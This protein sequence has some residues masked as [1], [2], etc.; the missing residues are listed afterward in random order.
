V[1][2]EEREVEEAE[3]TEGPEGLEDVLE[4][5]EEVAEGMEML[6][7]GASTEKDAEEAEV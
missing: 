1:G 6:G 3:V 4:G 5:S 7:E 2:T